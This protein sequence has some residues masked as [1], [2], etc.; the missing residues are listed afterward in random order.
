LIRLVGAACPMLPSSGRAMEAR[1]TQQRCTTFA[2]DAL[3][4]GYK[5]PVAVERTLVLSD[6]RRRMEEG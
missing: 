1:R 3:R 6:D 2:H 4:L 5:G